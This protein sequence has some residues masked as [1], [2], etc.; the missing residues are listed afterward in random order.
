MCTRILIESEYLYADVRG[1]QGAQAFS[2]CTWKVGLSV[3]EVKL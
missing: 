2:V 1:N 3:F